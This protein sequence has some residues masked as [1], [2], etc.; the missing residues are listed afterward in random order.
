MLRTTFTEA[1]PTGSRLTRTG[2]CRAE[3]GRSTARRTAGL[4]CQG[5]QGAGG[6]LLRVSADLHR[7]VSGHVEAADELID[8]SERLILLRDWIASVGSR[9]R[10]PV[11]AGVAHNVAG[12]RI[13]ATRS[14][15]TF[16]N[17]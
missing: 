11:G 17:T 10:V 9:V 6:L 12:R 2:G 1:G 3:Q 13:Y 4:G 5:Q 7:L 14:E 16:P 15:L 8:Q